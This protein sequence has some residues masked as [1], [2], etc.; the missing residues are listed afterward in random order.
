MAHT[1]NQWIQDNIRTC[2]TIFLTAV[3][4]LTHNVCRFYE[5]YPDNIFRVGQ[6][7]RGTEWQLRADTASLPVVS[8]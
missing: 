1:T 3:I 2:N 8:W 4:V 5:S 6:A 7:K